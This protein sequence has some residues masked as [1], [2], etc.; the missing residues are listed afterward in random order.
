MV[1]L[2]STPR[3]G[4]AA[5]FWAQL[6]KHDSLPLLACLGQPG[7]V[8]GAFLVSQLAASVLQPLGSNNLSS[9]MSMDLIPGDAPLLVREG[10]GEN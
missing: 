1:P 8:S 5:G 2:L 4:P 3:R 7:V 10:S 6:L 9:P